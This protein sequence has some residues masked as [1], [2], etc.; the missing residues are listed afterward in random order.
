[1]GYSN[2]EMH[3]LE[4]RLAEAREKIPW[5]W[6]LSYTAERALHNISFFEQGLSRVG[7]DF[8]VRV[9]MSTTSA[10][11]VVGLT[12]LEAVRDPHVREYFA[13]FYEVPLADAKKR[14]VDYPSWPYDPTPLAEAIR[15]APSSNQ[16]AS[17]T[18][19]ML[20]RRGLSLKLD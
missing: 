20:K 16:I 7:L 2:T 11:I 9:F 5:Y 4:P 14:L 19:M 15:R 10:G 6:T 8:P 18:R 17:R 1:M 3:L 13:S 12:P